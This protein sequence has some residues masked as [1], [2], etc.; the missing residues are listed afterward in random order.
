MNKE[1]MPPWAATLA[2]LGLTALVTACTEAENGRVVGQL[3]SDRIELSVEF[4]E[5][6]TARHVREGEPVG[7]GQ[8]LVEQD[9]SRIEARIEEVRALTSQAEARLAEMI[10]GPREERIRAAQATAVGAEQTV[11]YRRTELDRATKLLSQG[12]ASQEVL[13]QAQVG[14]DAAEAEL[15]ARRAL[16]EE[17]LAGTTAEELEQAEQAVNQG[18]AQLA[19]LQ[20]DRAR[21]RIVAPAAGVVDSLVFET[22]ERPSPGQPVVI[23]LAGKQPYARV[24]IR[25]QIRARIRPGTRAVVRVDGVSDALGGTVRWVS[26]EA[27]FTPYFALT[28]RD[29]GRLSFV[30][31]IDLDATGERLPDGV[32]VEV[33]FDIQ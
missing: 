6:I 28:E 11:R 13:D 33:E 17:L 10:R 23:L 8:L 12:L 16:L 7:E 22:G 15:R 32:P 25:E 31:K 9:A 14:L 5:P 4:A 20:V 26:S 1:V 3:E 24:Y 18:R 27:A 19:R 21:H 2:L 29:R 30:A